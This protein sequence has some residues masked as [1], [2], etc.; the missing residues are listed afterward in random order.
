MLAAHHLTGGDVD[1][2]PAAIGIIGLDEGDG[3]A[4]ITGQRGGWQALLLAS[5]GGQ[6]DFHHLPR[7]QGFGTGT[8]CGAH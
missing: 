5:R 6:L 8:D 2:S 3:L 7:A 4:M 1:E